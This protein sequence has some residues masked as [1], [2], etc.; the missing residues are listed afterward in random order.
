MEWRDSMKIWISSDFHFFH[1]NYC[2]GVSNW[3]DKTRCRDFDTIDEMN[4]TI[5]SNINSLVKEE[6]EMYCLG[7]FC[8]AGV[9]SYKIRE[10]INCKIIHYICGNHSNRHG[11]EYDPVMSCGNRVSSLF[12]SYGYYA[13]I[14]RRETR[15]NLFHYPVSSWNEMSGGSLMLFGHCHS[16]PENKFFNGGRSMDVGLDGNNLMPYLLDD[17]IDE[18]LAKP[19]KKEGHHV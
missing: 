19:V 13:E 3:P 6:D 17:V 9:D 10:K 18:L 11:K 4:N 8:F 5:I 16:S 2:R 14:F 15:I 1:K 12:S 7:D